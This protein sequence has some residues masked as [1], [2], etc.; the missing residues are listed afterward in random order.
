MYKLASTEIKE[1]VICTQEC[2]RHL[3]KETRAYPQ[4]SESL[5]S[6]FKE[7]LRKHTPPPIK[8]KWYS[9]T[10]TITNGSSYSIE[11][12]GV[13]WSFSAISMDTANEV[14]ALVTDD[15]SPSNRGKENNILVIFKHGKKIIE[16]PSVSK[17]VVVHA[18]DV[19]YVSEGSEGFH[20]YSNVC[21]Y[22]IEENKSTRI[23]KRPRSTQFLHLASDQSGNPYL[24]ITTYHSAPVVY[25]IIYNHPNTHQFQLIKT[26]TAFFIGNE[27]DYATIVH[28]RP[29]DRVIA[30]NDSY[31][32]EIERG[33]SILKYKN[34]N[35]LEVAGWI[36]PLKTGFDD[37]LVRPIDR[38]AFLFSQIASNK[39]PEIHI[40][41]EKYRIP[42]ISVKNAKIPT[43]KTLIVFYGS[44]GLRTR[45]IHPYQYWAPLLM[46]GWRICFIMA[47]GGGDNGSA[48]AMQG[49]KSY[50]LQTINDVVNG[51]KYIKEH[52]QCPW[53]KTAI[54][55][56]S[57]GGIP[58]GVVTLMGL[59]G[60]SFMEHPFVDVVETMGNP[61][62][63]LTEV[64]YGEF[65][66]PAIA[67]VRAK[68]IEV[69]P[70]DCK[71]CLSPAQHPKTRVMMR[72]GE[73]DTQVYPY[74]PL[75][76]AERLRGLGHEVLLASAVKEGHF[77][78]GEAWLDA[79]ARD[80]VILNSLADGEKISPR[81]IKMAKTHRNKNSRRNKNK[82]SQRNKNKNMDGGKRKSRKASR[83]TRRRVGRKH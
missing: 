62:L 41:H 13:S 51:I 20:K 71:H 80:L 9:Y 16:I 59:V 22:R 2:I 34:K 39:N 18:G 72:T 24:A 54:Y 64:E 58:A 10:I 77:Y 46:R 28:K 17:E 14:C 43:E 57:A 67:A 65:G 49:R 61:A 5:V 53:N 63:P 31:E 78:G 76:F 66:N 30:S 70:M 74:E 44:Y 47:R 48:W 36:D 25:K 19:F 79:R 8:Y 75:K 4:P 26:S 35:L 83:R 3:R 52:Y 7:E 21:V 29:L 15:D 69:S 45:T 27:T 81:D 56:R 32:I 40:A 55:A 6:Q 1:G 60:I 82:N 50:H 38:P 12:D 33:V 68:M 37:F 23:F 42:I 73:R 11:I